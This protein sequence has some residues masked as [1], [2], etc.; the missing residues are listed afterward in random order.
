MRFF[1]SV[2]PVCGPRRNHDAA[3]Q[4]YSSGTTISAQ[5]PTPDTYGGESDGHQSDDSAHYHDESSEDSEIILAW[6]QQSFRQDEEQNQQSFRQDEEPANANEPAALATMDPAQIAEH[7][8]RQDEADR[9]EQ[10]ESELVD[11]LH[12]YNSLRKN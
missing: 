4:N 3:A 1:F 9:E 10:E 12:Y 6:E 7:D 8:R 2:L 11:R 5:G